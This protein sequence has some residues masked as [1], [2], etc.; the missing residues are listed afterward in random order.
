MLQATDIL[1]DAMLQEAHEHQ[2]DPAM[3]KSHLCGLLIVLDGHVK[4][5]Q[6]AYSMHASGQE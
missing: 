3:R 5:G 4:V 2:D 6:T 1:N